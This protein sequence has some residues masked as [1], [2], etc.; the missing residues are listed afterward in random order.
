MNKQENVTWDQ[1]KQQAVQ[2]LLDTKELSGKDGAITPI[3]K[4]VIEAALEAKLKTLPCTKR[5]S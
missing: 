2:R 4:M 3:I 5:N 1:V